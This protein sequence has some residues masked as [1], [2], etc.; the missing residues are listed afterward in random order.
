[1]DF[2]NSSSAILRVC[3]LTFLTLATVC[4]SSPSCKSCGSLPI[5]LRLEKGTGRI[6]LKVNIRFGVKVRIK[7]RIRVMARSSFQFSI[8]Q[9]AFDSDFETHKTE[10]PFQ[11]HFS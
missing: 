8:I 4:N 1:M 5:R 3:K 10:D 11:P 6:G 2:R 9:S 7:V